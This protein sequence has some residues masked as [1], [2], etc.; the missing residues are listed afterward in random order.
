MIVAETEGV[1]GACVVE[2]RKSADCL[3]FWRQKHK[4]PP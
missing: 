4:V 3:P 2:E 1:R